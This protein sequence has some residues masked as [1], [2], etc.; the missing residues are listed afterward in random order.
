MWRNEV[1]RSFPGL[2]TART[3]LTRTGQTLGASAA[4]VSKNVQAQRRQGNFSWRV[5]PLLSLSLSPS[6]ASIVILL[7]HPPRH[8]FTSLY[9]TLIL[10]AVSDFETRS[11]RPDRLS[12][13]AS[14]YQ[15][16]AH[17]MSYGGGYGGGGRDGGRGYSNGYEYSN[18]GYGSYSNST[19]RYESYGYDDTSHP[20]YPGKASQLS[21]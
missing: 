2:I 1:L 6:P 3:A 18:G 12:F 10:F 5:C 20:L 7:S 17:I 4:S 13:D 11:L 19:S 9:Y 15:T 14:L 8:F 21:L 16:H